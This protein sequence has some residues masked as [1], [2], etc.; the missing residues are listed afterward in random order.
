MGLQHDHVS[1]AS[2]QQLKPEL[3]VSMT[4]EKY[5]CSS[6]EAKCSVRG[7]L[8]PS[9]IFLLARDGNLFLPSMYLLQTAVVLYVYCYS[10]YSKWTRCILS[11][12]KL[13]PEQV[14]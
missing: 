8:C 5:E 7:A 1:R 13:F 4:A 2:L 6:T 10:S 14:M 9:S 3:A 12:W 11:G